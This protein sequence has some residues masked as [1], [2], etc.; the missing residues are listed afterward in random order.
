VTENG[1]SAA[2]LVIGVDV[3]GTH[4]DVQVVAGE[5]FVRGKALTTYD[6][7]SR[8]LLEG[9]GVA[10]GQLGLSTEEALKQ[11]RLMVNA[12]TVVTNTL[13]SL[14]GAAVGVLVTTGFRDAFRF[15]GGPRQPLFD[16]HLQ[17]NVPDI[18]D[19]PAIVEIDGRIDAAGT[20]L[21]PLD[22]DAVR[23]AAKQLI[24]EQGVTALAVC[25][26]SSYINPEHELA[27]ERIIREA[28][29]DI[30]LSLSHQLFPVMRE[31]RRWTTAVLNSYVHRD[32]RTYLETVDEKI[33]G[34]GF[35]RTLAFYQGLGGDVSK[36]RAM[37]FPLSLLGSG[38]AAGAVGAAELARRMGYRDVLLGD[39][40]GTSFDAGVIRD[41]QVDINKRVDLGPF[42]TG[43]SIVDVVSI[44]A[45]GGSIVSVSDRGVPQVGP[46]SA[47]STPGPACYPNGGEHAT[48]TD[49]MVSLGFIDPDNYLG[50][51]IALDKGRAVAAMKSAL[52]D[53]FDW[54]VETAAVAV[55]DLAVTNMANAIRE[56][57]VRKGYDPSGF[58]FLAYGGSVGLFASQIATMVGASEVLIPRNS[59]VFCAQG[60]LSSDTVLRYDR[61]VSW[62]LDDDAAAGIDAVN[63]IAEEM[64]ADALRDLAGEGIDLDSTDVTIS[65]VGD[66]QFAG[67]VYELPLP[68]PEKV[69][70]DDVPRLA[71]EFA[72]RYEDAYGAG[73]AWAGGI[74]QMV[75]L[76][77]T[78]RAARERS[79][80]PTFPLE[81]ID[82]ATA[83]KGERTLYLPERHEHAT[84][85]VYDDERITPGTKVEGPAVIDA[86]DTTIFVPSGAVAVRD[87]YLN[88]RIT[89]T[90]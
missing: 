90:A 17:T 7:F 44:G 55:H 13:T 8:G 72:Q 56:I 14:D 59:S 82:A 50:G 84:V 51:R 74:P 69:T 22:E 35:D 60:L 49:A 66:F 46:A 16:D 64:V 83:V 15:A 77:V 38:P 80:P 3:G 25:F 32:A 78:V 67:Q 12:T 18:V 57:S 1:S 75:N 47:G 68:L 39:M 24:E 62:L 29:P 33:R 45:G 52:A 6:D 87:E 10:V 85:E 26:L 86:N 20:E 65:R 41:N 5:S 42:Q 30:F 19:R 2:D 31:T 76:T 79:E 43:V 81:P 27:A 11:G 40:G 48:L 89:T 71:A 54:D 23:A 36:G 73:T 61:T 4:T 34:G 63:E 28:H 9:L 37:R 53:R 21:L 88:Y 70:A 58:L